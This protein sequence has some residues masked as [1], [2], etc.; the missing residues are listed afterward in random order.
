LKKAFDKYL[1]EFE[2]LKRS[3]FG[4]GAPHK[5]IL[6]L[7]IL[8]G[9]RRKEIKSNVIYIT[10]ELI[11]CFRDLWSK[12]IGGS[13]LHHPRFYYPFFHMR[14]EPFW[15]LICK[16]G[17]LLPISSSRSVN[18]LRSLTESIA[19]AEIDPEL[20]TLLLN[21][22]LLQLFEGVLLKKYFHSIYS[23]QSDY[24]QIKNIGEQILKDDQKEYQN[25]IIEIESRLKKEDA[26]EEII[27]RNRI[28]KRE[29]P[30]IYEY[31]CAIS[32]MY[33]K[34][35][36]N[37]QMIDACHVVPFSIS[38]DDTIGNGISLCP[39]LHR[40]FD[41]GLLTIK[42]NYTISISNTISEADSPYSLNQFEG[43][44][45]MLPQNPHHHPLIE[46]LEWHRQNR[47]MR[48]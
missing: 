48:K 6:L 5:P 14:S 27:L 17:Y 36:D 24:S 32:G 41:R 8:D 28:F 1:F 7:S 13:S 21:P 25:R 42:N 2:H 35:S 43:K 4:G 11:V 10:P 33:I 39:N 34:N 3:S 46:N 18:G 12:L 16:N 40:A 15:K 19:Y 38:K 31:R 47:W 20:F 23:I 37:Y 29:I 22:E 44:L 26:D 45:I 30:R 9:V